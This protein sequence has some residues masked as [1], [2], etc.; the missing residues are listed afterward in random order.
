[1]IDVTSIAVIAV[2]SSAQQQFR[3]LEQHPVGA[4]K[5]APAESLRLKFADPGTGGGGSGGGGEKS[6]PSKDKP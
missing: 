6:P 4:P 5:L 1:M 2:L 3:A